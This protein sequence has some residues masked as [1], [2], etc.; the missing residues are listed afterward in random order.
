MK[1]LLC[2]MGMLSCLLAIVMVVG[3][4]IEG[5]LSFWTCAPLAVLFGMAQHGLSLLSRRPVRRVKR[6]AVPAAAKAKN[7]LRAA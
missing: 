7:S 3:G 1:K 6:A 4:L 2:Q 5:T